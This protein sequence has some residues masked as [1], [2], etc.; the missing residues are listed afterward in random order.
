MVSLSEDAVVVSPAL[1]SP[2][3]LV[4]VVSEEDAVVVSASVVSCADK[5]MIELILYH[6]FR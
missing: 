3:A 5:S 4:V 1:V 2:D 6:D